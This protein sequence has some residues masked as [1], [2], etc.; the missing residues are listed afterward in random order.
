MQA[1]GIPPARLFSTGLRTGWLRGRAGCV[2]GSFS[3][4][5]GRRGRAAAPVFVLCA[6]FWFS[7]GL[8]CAVGWLGSLL[9]CW[10]CVVGECAR[11][12]ACLRLRS[13]LREGRAWQVALPP[14]AVQQPSCA[15]PST[16]H[17]PRQARDA[18]LPVLP[19]A[20]RKVGVLPSPTPAAETPSPCYGLS[21]PVCARRHDAGE[22][23]RPRHWCGCSSARNCTTASFPKQRLKP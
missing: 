21:A 3:V 23:W 15:S 7:V 17:A 22:R 19:G 16:H 8:L 2:L 20:V 9:W 14:R 11:G 5:A 4:G 10:R 12:G 1:G 18:P 13:W 6:C